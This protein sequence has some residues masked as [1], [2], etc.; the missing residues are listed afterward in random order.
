MGPLFDTARLDA[1][2][3]SWSHL[4]VGLGLRSFAAILAGL[5]LVAMVPTCPC[6]GKAVAAGGEHACCAPPTGV[7]AADHGCCDSHGRTESDLLTAGSLPAPAPA[8][9]AVVRAEPVVRLG[10]HP[11]ASVL[12]SPSPPPAI[13]RI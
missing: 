11:H 8:G 4:P 7:R 3:S 1:A 13:L 9:V 10:A 2:S 12:S 6:S 5:A